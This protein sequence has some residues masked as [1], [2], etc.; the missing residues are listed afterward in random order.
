MSWDTF[1]SLGRFPIQTG[2]TPP[3]TPQTKLDVC[4]QNFFRI[5]TLHRVAGGRTA[6]KLQKGCTVL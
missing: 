3:L 4:I 5:L 6:R 2:P 1:A